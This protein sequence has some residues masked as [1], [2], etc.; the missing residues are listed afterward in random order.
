MRVH[1]LQLLEA[2]RKTAWKHGLFAPER[3]RHEVGA[4]GSHRIELTLQA[5]EVEYESPTYSKTTS[6]G[7]T[8]PNTKG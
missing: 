4:D 8:T 7:A 6:L 2:I 1:V 5:S 3:V